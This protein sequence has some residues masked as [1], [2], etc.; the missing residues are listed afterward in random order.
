MKKRIFVLLV[1][2]SAILSLPCF[3]NSAEPPGFTIVVSNPAD[4]LEVKLFVEE[5]GEM[6]ECILTT[7]ERGWERYYRFYYH[8]QILPY[9]FEAANERSWTII[10][11]Y[12]GSETEFFVPTQRLEKYSNI[13]TLDLKK[14]SLI[15]GEREWRAPVLIA[16]RIALTILIEGIIFY[17]FGYRE[18]SN[19]ILFIICNLITQT[20]L[21]ASFGGVNNDLY[22]W[23]LVFYA[24]EI[25]IFIAETLLYAFAFKEKGTK[26][27]I[28]CA[29]TANAASL[30][31]GAL[32]ITYLPV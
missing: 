12:N 27:A 2:L 14:G 8:D 25:F 5:N 29:L 31:L 18:K 24:T 28:A 16:S 9:S 23:Q 11:R 20:F 13:L 6:K 32:I 4:D 7:V 30:V 19:W 21:N 3:A 1:L 26:R 22:Y 17:I 10:A 15:V